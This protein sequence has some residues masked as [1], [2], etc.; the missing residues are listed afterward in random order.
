[1]VAQTGVPKPSSAIQAINAE[2][3][4]LAHAAETCKTTENQIVLFY[5][6]KKVRA[7]DCFYLFSLRGL[8]K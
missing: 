2:T 1:V 6:K 5:I 4:E 7:N 8:Y 3:L